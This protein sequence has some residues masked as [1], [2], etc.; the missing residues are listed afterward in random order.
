MSTNLSSFHTSVKHRETHTKVLPA[1][2]VHSSVIFAEVIEPGP[3]DHKEPAGND[4][5]PVGEN[6]ES[7]KTPAL[8]V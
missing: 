3:V 4:G 7:V 5:S 2:D 8:K 1:P 6:K